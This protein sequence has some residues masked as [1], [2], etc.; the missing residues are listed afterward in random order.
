MQ[1]ESLSEELR[2]ELE[3]KKFAVIR[4]SSSVEEP[5]DKVD[6]AILLDIGSTIDVDRLNGY[7]VSRSPK[8]WFEFISAPYGDDVAKGEEIVR[9][10]LLSA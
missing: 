2:I 9:N 1:Y 6:D 7:S 5:G 8:T 10:A 3:S 4:W